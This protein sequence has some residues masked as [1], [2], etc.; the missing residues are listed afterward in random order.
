MCQEGLPPKGDAG[1]PPRGVGRQRGRGCRVASPAENLVHP[2]SQ[3]DRFGGGDRRQDHIPKSRRHCQGVN[4]DA[5]RDPLGNLDPRVGRRTL[6]GIRLLRQPF[7]FAV[8]AGGR[9]GAADAHAPAATWQPPRVDRRIGT[10]GRARWARV[11][12]VRDGIRP[13]KRRE[14]TGRPQG[15]EAPAGNDPT[16]SAR[17]DG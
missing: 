2:R 5:Q 8:D 17:G 16:L 14:K 4:P 6:L 11:V 12:R 10:R 3:G 15:C 1:V 7:S 13:R 9:V